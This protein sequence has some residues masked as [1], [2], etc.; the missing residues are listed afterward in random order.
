MATDT[1]DRWSGHMRGL[2]VTT[3]AAVSGVGAALVASVVTASTSPVAAA[4]D[5]LG[6]YVLAGDILVQFPVL[7]L[8]GVDVGDFSA[9]DYLYVA[10]MT[11]SFWFVCWTVLLTTGTTL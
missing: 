4:S 7:R 10:F 11:F 8:V 6:L 9:K 2:L 3:L 5:R 1:V